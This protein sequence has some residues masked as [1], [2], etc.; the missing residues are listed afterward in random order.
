MK[1]GVSFGGQK[2][3][4]TGASGF[5]GSRLCRRLRTA[6]A[7]VHGIS[8]RQRDQLPGDV[9]WWQGD[10]SESGAVS[11]LMRTIRPDVVFHLASHVAGSRD[12]GLVIPT[13][14]DNLMTTVNLLTAAAKE[15]CQRFVLTGSMEEPDPA[16]AEAVP[17]SPYA[18]AK[19]AGSGYADMFHA[20]YDF[21]VVTLRVFMVY[22]PGQKD[23]KKLIPYVILSLLRGETPELG[24]G[25]RPVDWIYVDDVVDAFMAAGLLEGLDGATVD[26]GSGESSTI[27]DI[28]ERLVQFIDPEITPAF[29]ARDDRPMERVVLADVERSA[30]LLGW[31]PKTSLEEG[32][33]RTIESYRPLVQEGP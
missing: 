20:L 8:R 4:V 2:V 12:L 24:S 9:R 23:L 26:V 13:F 32:L 5:I 14:R 10:A 17:C 28:V 30:R 29:G 3:L 19:W 16:D 27:R 1:Q 7:E 15:G 18:A 31:R 33:K 21:P 22:G 11:T 6:G 25:E